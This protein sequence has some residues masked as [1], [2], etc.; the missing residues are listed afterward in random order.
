MYIDDVETHSKTD[1]TNIWKSRQ[2]G[3]SLHWF[4]IQK[5]WAS[6]WAETK[7]SSSLVFMKRWKRCSVHFPVKQPLQWLGAKSVTCVSGSW[8][9]QNN[10]VWVWGNR[11]TGET[12]KSKQGVLSSPVPC[13]EAGRVPLWGSTN[14]CCVP[15]DMPTRALWGSWHSWPHLFVPLCWAELRRWHGLASANRLLLD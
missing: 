1:S 14:S 12:T 13:W 10:A 3:N 15:R 11:V 5:F 2:K 4:E 6:R 9:R 8:T 7:A